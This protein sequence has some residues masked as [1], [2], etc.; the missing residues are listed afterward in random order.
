MEYE[1]VGSWW[2]GQPVLRPRYDYKHGNRGTP[3]GSQYGWGADREEVAEEMT[4]D[5]TEINS[6]SHALEF[7]LYPHGHRGP[8]I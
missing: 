2:K 5:Q 1:T 6:L 8:L 4:W 3:G 7:V